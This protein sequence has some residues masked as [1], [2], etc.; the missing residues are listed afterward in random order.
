MSILLT[1]LRRSLLLLCFW[2]CWKW[3][4]YVVVNGHVLDAVW[5]QGGG[6][7]CLWHNNIPAAAIYCIKN[8]PR[9]FSLSSASADGKDV[10]WVIGRFKKTKA[11]EG[12]RN[13]GGMA[14]FYQLAKLM[15]KKGTFFFINPDG[16][17][18]PRYRINA[19][20]FL[21][22]AKRTQTP[23]IPLHIGLEHCWELGT[24][25]R[26]RIPKPFS[27]SYVVFGDP[28][29]LAAPQKKGDT[30]EQL[31]QDSATLERTM[32]L[33]ALR[34]TQL[35]KAKVDPVLSDLCREYTAKKSP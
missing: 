32:H 3:Q 13:R 11:V 31:R 8:T 14:A 23:I 10:Q 20:G 19:N 2:L 25:D 30:T 26:A 16:S 21:M 15:R 18:G 24:W 34:T 6:I 7:L 35:A 1:Y 17:K 28:I 9:I 12:S 22:L 29:W 5:E 33:H 4:R 27:R